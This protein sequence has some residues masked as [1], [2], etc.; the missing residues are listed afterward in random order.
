M[1]ARNRAGTQEEFPRNRNLLSG[2]FL[3]GFPMKVE[4]SPGVLVEALARLGQQDMTAVTTKQRRTQGFF[5][6]VNALASTT[7]RDLQVMADECFVERIPGQKDGWRLGPKLV[8]IGL[9]HMQGMAR[10]EQQINEVKQR[11]SR[12]P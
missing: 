7:T 9:A 12:E 8:Q 4:D 5:Q 6:G 10:V 2:D 1:F 3:S 11:F